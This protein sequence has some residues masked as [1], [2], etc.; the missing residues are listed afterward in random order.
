[1]QSFIH[2]SGIFSSPIA[3]FIFAFCEVS[4]MLEKGQIVIGVRR[5]P[6]LLIYVFDFKRNISSF[7]VF[8]ANTPNLND[9]DFSL[10]WLTEVN[11]VTR[12]TIYDFNFTTI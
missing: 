7:I 9:L 12:K 11:N 8:S 10:P 3:F 2:Y 6:I 1:M 5:Y 4:S